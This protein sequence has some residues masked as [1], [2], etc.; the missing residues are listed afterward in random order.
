MEL[1]AR[2]F[3]MSLSHESLVSLAEKLN[4]L[5]KDVVTLKKKAES[6]QDLPTNTPLAKVK[7]EELK[8]ELNY[9]DEKLFKK[10]EELTCDV[11]TP[12]R[13]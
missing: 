8:Q 2:G 4:R 12:S 10:L 6:Y 11:Q 1:A 5:Q 9:L 13:F 7:V 3:D